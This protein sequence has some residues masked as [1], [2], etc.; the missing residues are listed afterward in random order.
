MSIAPTPA[1]AFQRAANEGQ[2]RLDQSMIELIATGFIAGLT[3]IF[4]MVALGTVEALLTGASHGTRRIAGALA[5]A[6]GVVFLVV[7]RAELFSENFFDP[8]ATIVDRRNLGMIGLLF[9]LWSVTFLLNLLGGGFFAWILSLEG[10]LPDGAPAALTRA[11]EEIAGRGNLVFFVKAISGGALVTLLSF[12]LQAVNTV[13]SRIVMAYMVGF[14]LTIGPFDH[15]VVTSLH[16]LF[17]IFL[18]ARVAIWDLARCLLI[19]TAGNL[20]GGLGLV[21]LT[22]I[23]QAKG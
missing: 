18:D 14:L 17:G 3:I 15:V 19:V 13:N 6:P 7:G 21:T 23:A 20:V 9:R 16:V 1:E 8:V 5:F 12:L 4:G 2:R 10:A 11:A 22:H